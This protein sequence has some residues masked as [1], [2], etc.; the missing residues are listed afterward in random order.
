MEVLNTQRLSGKLCDVK[1]IVED[2]E[3]YAH[4][5]ILVANS[6]FF[7]AMCNAETLETDKTRVTLQHIQTDLAN[8]F[9]LLQVSNFLFVDEITKA[10]FQNL[11]STVG[12]ENCFTIRTI[13]DAFS[14]DFLT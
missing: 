12:T 2:N 6:S 4:R 3:V 11:E 1:L 8:V 7:L 9:K 14:C 5:G 13:A 10:C